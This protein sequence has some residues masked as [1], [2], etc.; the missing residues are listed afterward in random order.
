M[1]LKKLVLSIV[2]FLFYVSILIMCGYGIV[3]HSTNLG[4]SIH[5]SIT[6]FALGIIGALIL[7]YDEYHIV[8]SQENSKDESKTNSYIHETK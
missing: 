2:E 1:L 7:G 8:K 5:D 3:R 4:L 6:V